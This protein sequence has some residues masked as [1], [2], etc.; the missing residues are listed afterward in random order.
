MIA[1][2]HSALWAHYCDLHTPYLQTSHGFVFYHRK[3]ISLRIIL[4]CMWQCTL[5]TIYSERTA[6]CSDKQ[7]QHLL[8]GGLLGENAKLLWRVAAPT[9]S[10]TTNMHKFIFSPYYQNL[11]CFTFLKYHLRLIIFYLHFFLTASETEALLGSWLAILL[12][13]SGVCS[14]TAFPCPVMLFISY[15][16]IP[17]NLHIMNGILYQ[18][19]VQL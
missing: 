6:R 10:E 7:L 17:K 2:L 11:R 14:L 9:S 12:S 18:L 13:R 5:G 1:V 16:L 3:W 15:I 8:D 19:Y 4:A